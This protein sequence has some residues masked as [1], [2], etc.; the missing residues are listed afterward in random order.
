MQRDVNII[1][2]VRAA[3]GVHA[4]SLRRRASFAPI[5]SMAK[6]A[7]EQSVGEVFVRKETSQAQRSGI[8]ASDGGNHA[9]TDGDGPGTDCKNVQVFVQKR[10]L[11]SLSGKRHLR[12]A[13][14][15]SLEV[16]TSVAKLM[17]VAQ[18]V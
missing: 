16:E 8:F 11:M 6:T 5:R 10:Q 14:V 12:A 9:G 13:S 1:F 15:G 18:R 2:G 7:V 17:S 4:D 3:D